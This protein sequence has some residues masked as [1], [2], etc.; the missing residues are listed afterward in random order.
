MIIVYEQV[1]SKNNTF[2]SL[3]IM[4]DGCCKDI[5]L[6]FF[7]FSIDV[8]IKDNLLLKRDNSDNLK[9]TEVFGFCHF[10]GAK[11]RCYSKQEYE[12]FIKSLSETKDIT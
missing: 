6:W 1:E 4:V 12:D 11:H 10:C 8:I 9:N 2:T 5:M 3:P 7:K